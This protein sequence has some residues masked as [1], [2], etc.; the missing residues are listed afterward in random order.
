MTVNTFI[1]PVQF[2]LNQNHTRMKNINHTKKALT[3]LIQKITFIFIFT[4]ICSAY[5]YAAN[6]HKTDSLETLL[7]TVNKNK[8]AKLL[9]ELAKPYLPEHPENAKKN[10]VWRIYL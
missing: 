9:N 1:S 8:K 10:C 7:K 3:I 2:I 4:V 6:T 5:L